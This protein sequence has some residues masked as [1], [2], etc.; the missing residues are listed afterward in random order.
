MVSIHPF[1]YIYFNRFVDRETPEYLRS[2][3]DMSYWGISNLQGLEFLMD[4]Y[5]N[6]GLYVKTHWAPV[7]HSARILPKEDW[8]ARMVRIRGFLH[9][10]LP[11]A[12]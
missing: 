9:Y 8:G 6:G 1:Q 12:F 10:A 7:E 3:Y 2:Q 11:R 5:P 4:E